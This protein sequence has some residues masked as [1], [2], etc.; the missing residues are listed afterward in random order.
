MEKF[1][2][3]WPRP[4]DNIPRSS[5]SAFQNDTLAHFIFICPACIKISFDTYSFDS[6]K[7]V[8]TIFL[9]KLGAILIKILVDLMTT[10]DFPQNPILG[11]AKIFK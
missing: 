2:S 3:A 10:T 1:V 11:M 6:G 5:E 7:Y 9:V 8:A 4:Q